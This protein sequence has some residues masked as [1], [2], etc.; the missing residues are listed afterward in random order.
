MLK[1]IIILFVVLLI[2]VA[3]LLLDNLFELPHDSFA[4]KDEEGNLRHYIH[5]YS[6]CRTAMVLKRYDK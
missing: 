2:H 1:K 6:V 3:L 4:K 5:I